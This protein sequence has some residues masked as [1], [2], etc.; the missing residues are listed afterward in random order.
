MEAMASSRMEGSNAG[1]CLPRL[2]SAG[3]GRGGFEP[4]DRRRGPGQVHRRAGE[5]AAESDPAAV[6]EIGDNGL[7]FVVGLCILTDG[8]HDVEKC[9]A[10]G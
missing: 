1:R 3:S 10:I 4:G 7:Q 9:K 2:N 6:D 5:A 8:V